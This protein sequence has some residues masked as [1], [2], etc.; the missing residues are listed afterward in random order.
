MRRG[1]CQPLDHDFPKKEIN[2]ELRQLRQ[3]HHKK[4]CYIL[5]ILLH[6]N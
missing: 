1:S 2:E 4:G 6:I 3:L 5:F